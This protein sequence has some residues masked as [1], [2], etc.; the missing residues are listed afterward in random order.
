MRRL[1]VN[2]CLLV[3]VDFTRGEDVGV[4]IVGR[5]TGGKVDIINAF[6][7][8]EAA[9]L[10]RKLITVKKGGGK[11]GSVTNGGGMPKMPVQE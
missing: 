9:D 10:Y 7:G 8:Q 1:H 11:N 5:Q 6:E 2:E 4:L 3:G